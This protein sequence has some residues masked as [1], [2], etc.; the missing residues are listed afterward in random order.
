MLE[1]QE[2]EKSFSGIPVLKGVGFEAEQ[3]K[4]T[5]LVGENGAGKSTLMKILAGIYQDYKGRILL[6]GREIRPR[7][8]RQA[9]VLGVSIIHQE[10]NLIPVLSIAENLFLGSEP[11]T[12]M[13]FID[14]NKMFDDA[15]EI[16]G[17]FRFPYDAK[18]KIQELDVCWQQIVEIARAFSEDSKVVVLDEPTSALT[19]QEIDVLFT[20]IKV[21]KEKNKIII[22][23]SHRLNE[24]FSISDDIVVLRD[25]IFIDKNKSSFISKSELISQMTGKNSFVVNSYRT[26]RTTKKKSIEIKNLEYNVSKNLLVTIP[27]LTL[28]QGDILGVA[29]VMGSGKSDLLRV[30]FGLP[31]SEYS[32]RLKV[33]DQAFSPN[34]P[35]NSLKNGVFYL[36]NNRKEEGIF[37]QLDLVQNTT[38]SI[39][40]KLASAV[41]NKRREKTVV[42]DVLREYNVNFL[43]EDTPIQN[44]SGGNQQ[45]VLLS[46]G[47]LA[48]PRLL[49]LDEPTRGIDVGAK[50]E[51]YNLL[52]RLSKKGVTMIISSSEIPELLRISNKIIVMA[53]G[54][55]VMQKSTIDTD[56]EEIL[57]HCFMVN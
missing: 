41:I 25:G 36:T 31:G 7:N 20:K 14:Y 48:N 10:L 29:G 27:E 39:L 9:K 12:R 40:D 28:D 18:T 32:C 37:P 2:I 47:A 1:F 43:S 50:E 26:K 21:L 57:K 38:I 3:G 55:V 8:P 13:G 16:L 49:L 34:S 53:H 44:L 45:K 23:I 5:A 42:R 54:K 30:L 56:E 24:I 46:R 22:F 33:G 15:K 11:L 19:D 6:E 4:V 35:R 52:E 17:T 51:I